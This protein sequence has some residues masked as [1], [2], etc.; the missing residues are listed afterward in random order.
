MMWYAIFYCYIAITT[1]YTTIPCQL[2][3]QTTYGKIRG[4]SE[5]AATGKQVNAWY[6]VPYAEKPIG[7]LRFRPSIP[8]QP[9]QD[10]LDATMIPP[11]CVQTNRSFQ[12]PE[13]YFPGKRLWIPTHPFSEDCL[14][15]TIV[16]P[17]P[18]PQDASV[19]VW[20]HG[21]GFYSGS[22]SQ[23]FYDHKILASEENVIVASMQYRVGVFGFLSLEREI[24]GNAG[25]F[26][27]AMALQWIKDNI[28]AFGGNP[29]SITIFGESAGAGS[30]S[31]HL[32][33][34][35][36]SNL[37]SRGIMQSGVATAPWA[38]ATDANMANSLQLIKALGCPDEIDLMLTC[39]QE[40]TADLI[41]E[42][43]DTI[44]RRGLVSIPFFPVIDGTLVVRHPL[45]TLQNG[46]YDPKNVIVGVTENE[47]NYF[48]LYYAERFNN[49]NITLTRDRFLEEIP[50]TVLTDN[51][52]ELEAI[53]YEYT[54]WSNP[55]DG[56]KNLVAL[57][58]IL[59]DKYFTCSSYDFAKRF[60]ERNDLYFYLYKHR[61]PQ[62]QWPSWGGAMH[63]DEIVFVFG[64]PLDP[65]KNY[66]SEQIEFSRQ[67]M[68]Y[69]ANF[70]RTGSPNCASGDSCEN[71]W[72]L[73][74]PDNPSYINLDVDDFSVTSGPLRARQ[75]VFWEKFLPKLL[76]EC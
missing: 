29:N 47:G 41:I 38:M 60:S 11:V 75:C 18:V 58:K 50:N 33:S 4:L 12:S 56:H 2:T 10:T 52:I 44:P 66:T 51:P 21:G 25:L 65:S 69:W 34:P 55:N 53:V 73:F 24:N 15:L 5:T 31:H 32:L 43:Q 13:Q 8:P 26:D 9:W 37:F 45:E 48:L 16:A 70:A 30:V 35:V 1:L 72:P 22:N 61:N 68:R 39:L 67:M 36:S 28:A 59:S 63:A 71:T 14:Y 74:E 23:G 7:K 40:A 64:E 57:E 49:E 46:L 19:M 42:A 62:N 20:I 27:Q 17:D 6:G 76:S 54:D 3:V